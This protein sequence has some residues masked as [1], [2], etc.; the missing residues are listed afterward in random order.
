LFVFTKIH[1]RI[2]AVDTKKMVR[3]IKYF[4]SLATTAVAAIIII[5]RVFARITGPRRAI[6]RAAASRTRGVVET[7]GGRRM[8]NVTTEATP[9]AGIELGHL[10]ERADENKSLISQSS[11]NKLAVKNEV[12]AGRSILDDIDSKV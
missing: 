5:A 3:I 7:G 4:I 2:N 12:L 9:F 8:H 11:G 6:V 1:S 10:F